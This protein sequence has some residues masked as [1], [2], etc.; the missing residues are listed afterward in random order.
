[1][2]KNIKGV[3]AVGPNHYDR[4][5]SATKVNVVVTATGIPLSVQIVKA[6]VHDSSLTSRAIDE[7]EL[8]IVG[9]RVIADKGYISEKQ[10]IKC[11]KQSIT[12]ICPYRKNQKKQNTKKELMLLKDRYIVEH[13]FSWMKN[14]RK[15]RMRYD[16][17]VASF[18]GFVMLACMDIVISKR[19]IT[20]LEFV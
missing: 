17:L 19:K 13:F 11:K 7:I 9:S 18:E 12:L 5:R 4:Y 6:S 10:R 8:K 2:I 20:S 14:Y 15:L 16:A 3:D 1:M